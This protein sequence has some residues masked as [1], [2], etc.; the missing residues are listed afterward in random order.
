MYL[1]YFVHFY[2]VDIFYIFQHGSCIFYFCNYFEKWQIWEKTERWIPGFGFADSV[3]DSKFLDYSG[4][5]GPSCILQKYQ[6]STGFS[7]IV[8]GSSGWGW[9]LSILMLDI[10]ICG[11]FI[12]MKNCTVLYYNN[13]TLPI[14]KALLTF[15]S[16]RRNKWLFIIVLRI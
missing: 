13:I 15:I 6:E 7:A 10:N 11:V 14:V 3:D 1:M 16:M 2:T 4:C 8:N 5:R 9:D 12:L